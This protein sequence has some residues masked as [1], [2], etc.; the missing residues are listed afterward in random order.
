MNMRLVSI[1]DFEFIVSVRNHV[2]N[3]IYFFNSNFISMA[4]QESFYKK[5]CEDGDKYF[6]AEEGNDRI[7]VA[8]LYNIDLVNN[9]CK[10]GRFM[11][12]PEHKNKKYGKS[13]LAW[14]LGYGFVELGVNRIYLD[15]F[16]DNVAAISLYKKVGFIEEGIF[17]EHIYHSGAY[18][19]VMVMGLLKD[20]FK[21]K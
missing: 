1:H 7:G 16:R 9:R 13:M 3:R 8:S 2:D 11:I 19:D 21:N 5:A 12:A 10:F 18:K 17:R 6:I 20:E 15:T 4:D 14:V